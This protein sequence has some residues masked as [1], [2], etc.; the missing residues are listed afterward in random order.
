MKDDIDDKDAVKVKLLQNITARIQAAYGVCTQDIGDIFDEMKNVQKTEYERF[1]SQIQTCQSIYQIKIIKETLVQEYVELDSGLNKNQDTAFSPLETLYRE[2]V[3][4]FGEPLFL[5][6]L[7]LPKI[8]K[9]CFD[10]LKTSLVDIEALKTQ[11]EGDCEKRLQYLV[12]MASTDKLVHEFK[13]LVE[14][15]HLKF[16]TFGFLI[17]VP[18]MKE[19]ELNSS[20]QTLSINRKS[21]PTEINDI[22]P[23]IL[24][25]YTMLKKYNGYLAHLG[26]AENAAHVKDLSV[27]EWNIINTAAPKV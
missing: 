16:M 19:K 5:N 9:K 12:F 3:A 6:L 8:R 24:N 18:L 10:K 27:S 21:L 1:G 11:F 17:F 2:F 14:S 26:L 13:V 22:E 20:I 7:D 25:S 23:F 15:D 4:Q